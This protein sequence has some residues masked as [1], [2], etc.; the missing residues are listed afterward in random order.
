MRALYMRHWLFIALFA[1][2]AAPAV[3][4]Q[5]ELVNGI[6]VIVNDAV[7]TYKDLQSYTAEAV[8]VLENQYRDQPQLLKQKKAEAQREA[9]DQL[10]EQQL[11]LHDFKTSGYNLPDSYIDDLI[12]RNIRKRYSDRTTLTKSLQA[13]G[14]TFEG[15]RQQMRERIIVDLLYQ[16]NVS[17][18]I[19]V[20][21][22]R[23]ENFYQEHTNQFA[24][25]EQVKLRMIVLNKPPGSG[26]E[27]SKLAAEIHKKLEEGAPFAEMAT[28]YSDG[29]Q[30]GQGGDWGWVERTVLRKELADVAFALKTGQ[31]IGVVDMPEVCY[32][33]LAEDRRSAQVKPLA[34]VTEEIERGLINQERARLQKKYIDRLKKNSFIRSF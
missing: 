16:R 20:S 30:R 2:F 29:S 27:V 14:K 9:L 1:A 11:M 33:M 34:D 28:I 17:G 15:Y 22:T 4:A 5:P 19:L 21:P 10:V 3:H 7:I 8:A 32:L 25:T 26:A 12:Q 24:V 23:I 6:A 13:E 31:K 18:E